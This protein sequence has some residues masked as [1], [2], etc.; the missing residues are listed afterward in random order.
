M[1]VSP[2][3]SPVQAPVLLEPRIM[4]DAN[5]EWDL[6]S[7]TALSS[8]LSGLAQSFAEQYATID[9]VE[10]SAFAAIGLGEA[11]A[12][13]H[14]AATAGVS[15]LDAVLVAVERVQLA[16]STLRTAV[17]EENLD[18]LRADGSDHSVNASGNVSLGQ[19]SQSGP[20]EISMIGDVS[21]IMDDVFRLDPT[22]RYAYPEI[23]DDTAPGG[24]DLTT[25]VVSDELSIAEILLGAKNRVVSDELSDAEILLGAENLVVSEELSVAEVLLG[26]ENLVV[27]GALSVAETLQGSM[28]GDVSAI[29]DDVFLLDPAGRYAYPEIY[30]D[31]AP[32]VADLA[33]RVVSEE[34]SVDE[35]LLGAEKRVVSEELSVAEILLG[36]ENL[37]VSEE[38]S[39]AEPLL[40]AEKRVVSRELSD[41]EILLGAENLVVSGAHSVAE[42]L[43]GSMIGDVSAI[44]DDVFRLDP[45]G[46]YA[47]PEIYDDTAPGGS[48]LTTRVVSDQLSVAE[49]SL[50]AKNRVVSE[51]LSVAEILL[52]SE[53]LVVSEELSVAEISLGAKNRVVSD[54]LSVAEILLGAENL[55]VSEEPSVAEPLLGA[56]KR[57]VSKELSDLEILLGSE[58]LVVSGAL[59]VAETLQGSMIGDVSAI[60]DDVFL[61][62]PAGRYAYP[63]IYDDT[64]PGVADLAKRVVSEEL[65][66]DEILLGAEKRVVSEELSVAEILLGAENLVVSEEPSVAEPL[67]GAEKRVV[68]RELSDLEILLGAENLVVSGAHSVAE[69]LQGSM[70]GDV[71]AIMD[72]VFRLDPA[73]RYAYPEI[74]D[75]TAPGVT[76]LAKRVV[77]EELSVDEISLGAETNPDFHP[78]IIGLGLNSWDANLIG[79]DDMSWIQGPSLATSETA[80]AEPVE[81]AEDGALQAVDATSVQPATVARETAV[82]DQS[83]LPGILAFDHNP[84]AMDPDSLLIQLDDMESAGLVGSVMA[85]ARSEAG[86]AEPYLDSTPQ[87]MPA[88]SAGLDAAS[89]SDFN[90]LALLNDPA[91]LLG[92][93]YE[94]FQEIDTFFDEFLA[95]I[96]LPIIGD[97]L[98]T[99]L[100]F[101][102]DVMNSVILPALEYAETPLADGSLP[103]T[104]ELINGFMNDALNDVFGTDGVEYLH[105]FLDTSGSTS[106]SF[107]Y[108]A[109]NFSG[110]LFS[111]MLDIDFDFGVPGLNIEVEEGSAIL[112]ELIYSVNIGFGLDA[113]GFFLL[114]DTDEAEV[115]IEFLV[116]AGTFSG[117]MSVLNLLGLSAQAV[118]TDDDGI[119]ISDASTDGGTAR[120]TAFLEADLFGESGDEIARDF[121]NI[122]PLD[123]EGNVLTYERI[124]YLD[125]LDFGELVAFD[126]GADID[127][128]IGVVGNI[129]DPFS[130]DALEIGG[131]QILPNVAAEL[132]LD[133]T[134]SLADG[135]SV[136][137]LG[138]HNVRVDA[139]QLYDALIRPL[140]DPIMSIVGPL[141]EVIDVIF[142]D[143]IG[144]LKDLAVDLIALWFPIIKLGDNIAEIANSIAQFVVDIAD[145]GGMVQFGSFDFT[146]YSDGLVSGET[147]ASDIDLTSLDPTGILTDDGSSGFGTFGNPDDGFSVDIPLLQDPFAALSLLL[148]DFSSVELVRA[149]YTWFNIDSADLDF[150]QLLIDSLDLPGFVVDALNDLEI[151]PLI[152]NRITGHGITMFEVGYDMSG[153]Q[154]FLN[155]YD[156][157]RLFDGVFIEAGEGSLVDVDLDISMFANATVATLGGTG[158]VDLAFNITDPND[159]GVVR[160]SELLDAILY[161]VEN[162]AITP[163]QQIAYLLEG[164]MQFGMS[165][166]VTFL[167]VTHTLY[168]VELPPIE[169]EL[170]DPEPSLVAGLNGNRAGI[171]SLQGLADLLGVGG[172]DE[173]GTQVLNLG[174]RIMGANSD[175]VEDGDD[176][177]VMGTAANR[178]AVALTNGEGSLAGEIDSNATAVV[179]PAG[180]GDNVIDMSNFADAAS[181]R[182]TLTYSGGGQDTIILPVGGLNVVFSGNGDDVITAP[183]NA[184][185]TYIIFAE[186][187]ADTVNIP[188]GNV[189]VFSGDDYGM[190]DVFLTAF[191]GGD[192]TPEGVRALL[193][194]MADD[195]ADPSAEGFYDIG[196]DQ[197]VNLDVLLENY[198]E[199]SQLKGDRDDESIT[200]GS[201]NHILLTGK[202]SDTIR[203]D[204]DGLGQVTV[205]SGAGDDNIEIGG[206]TVFVEGGAGSD[207]IKVNGADVE[208]WG[209]GKAAGER[210]SSGLAS[211]IDA[212]AGNDGDDIIIGGS[213]DDRLYGQGGD[214]LIEGNGGADT[215]AGG[216]GNDVVAGGTFDFSLDG[217]AVDIR[218]VDL[219]ASIDGVLDIRVLDLSDG[220]DVIRGGA[221]DDILIGGGGADIVTG[222]SGLDL[223]AGDFAS[224]VLTG[225]MVAQRIA[226][227]HQDS[228]RQGADTIDSGAMNDILIGGGAGDELRSPSGDNIVLGDFGVV[229]GDNIRAAIASIS[230]ISSSQ[231][232]SDTLTT[233]RGNDQLIGGE[234]GDA[235]NS[236]LGVDILFGDN[237]N[238]DF[239]GLILT[240]LALDTDGDDT[241]VLGENLSGIEPAPA[242]QNDLA[243]GG[244]GD[245][246]V[247]AGVGGLTLIGD[248]GEMVLRQ[249][250]WQALAGYVDPGSAPSDA[251]LAQAEA[252]WF[253]F[254]ALV[255]TARTTANVRDGNDLVTVAGGTNSMALGGGDD[256][257]E[258]MAGLNHVLADDGFMRTLL[259]EDETIILYEMT[260]T[261]MAAAS[262]RDY[263]FA[264]DGNNV[265]IGGEQGDEIEVG[266][267]F[268]LILGDRGAFLSSTAETLGYLRSDTSLLGGDDRIS[269]GA[270]NA[271]IVAGQGADTVLVGAGDDIAVG[272][273]AD[274]THSHGW[275][276]LSLTTT[277]HAQ[278]GNDHLTAA[279]THGD[280]VLMGQTGN[281]VIDGGLDDDLLAGDNVDLEF[282]PSEH[283]FAGQSALDRF[284]RLESV[285]PGVDGDDLLQGS[286]GTDYLVGGF[287]DDNL[288]GGD[289]QDFLIGDTAIIGRAYT[290]DGSGLLGELWIDTNFAYETGGYDLLRGEAGFD[291]MI[292]N[293]GP[294]LFFGDTEEDALFSDG[295]AG[296]FTTQW[297]SD[298]FEQATPHWQLVQV[299]FAGPGAIDIVSKAQSAS[300]IGLSLDQPTDDSVRSRPAMGALT[301]SDR[302]SD[303]FAESGVLAS[304]LDILMDYVMGDMLMSAIAQ[305]M[306]I[307]LEGEALRAAIA[308]DLEAFIVQELQIDSV[309]QMM[310]LERVMTIIEDRLQLN[311]SAAA[312]P[313]QA[314]M[315]MLVAAE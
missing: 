2:V 180:E 143:P 277:N 254:D 197:P 124:V 278:G 289:G 199:I 218:D 65:S 268:N 60:M 244:L 104:L 17:F 174:A 164:V 18:I 131:N 110:K 15:D 170:F 53:N 226:S 16:F 133:A 272:D 103:S 308:A 292:G 237:A 310:L 209:W 241:L 42:T 240:G 211:K 191:A 138:I 35:I 79:F 217:T 294:D 260:S 61:L 119:I 102:D 75:D 216:L 192:V 187:G 135:L 108:G 314:D 57:V 118:T 162:G 295:F 189:I 227:I 59:S 315:P 43:Q 136:D 173:V 280:N 250:A 69:T 8:S 176:V 193:G 64:A 221:G 167:G 233:G 51:E 296:Y 100:T 55:V 184:Q 52:G 12:G 274:I 283:G 284:V 252:A 28:I 259:N 236:G 147:N 77:S 223:I 303:T 38:P 68:S 160:L 149:R 25:R 200:V 93:I 71:S 45:A 132:V 86:R 19:P 291:V 96:D 285:V 30:D 153:I 202:G 293:L 263:I 48:D 302:L 306:A 224:I 92:G 111:E 31:T 204:L 27:S 256:R 154:N 89:L 155:S 122:A 63:E 229:E 40:G 220:N 140:V 177:V 73:G 58:N 107:I 276:I 26:A 109:I 201:G 134:F 116:D 238:L 83:E 183:E 222:A 106:E 128:N 275:E 101:F 298:L 49:N 188:G 242:D 85:L 171:L 126:F 142:Q 6:A 139:S 232:G 10:N 67:L 14:V 269:A 287:G 281:D 159:D 11:S 196:S 157:F 165:A 81:S 253:L 247:T 50:G 62:D 210:G 290:A 262:G 130:G 181:E 288:F 299:N 311:Q 41:L 243:F 270:G 145:S 208:V 34:L 234:A 129:L 245:D 37:V 172:G 97:A 70:I 212:L 76:D 213:G 219:G 297:D 194:L 125:A 47:Y 261:D 84:V 137:A 257:A 206:T 215:L 74:Y 198:T 163:H 246:T 144:L 32:G 36:A 44:M 91:S 13:T 80:S 203:G 117:S 265:I 249:E 56:E 235:L 207:T 179:I 7:T 301:L 146:E 255:D 205:L 225:K 141:L 114:N 24:S 113:D 39:V 190:R 54:E 279:G 266:D 120:L 304:Q 185:G 72:D 105:A 148:G 9:E 282:L 267:G 88:L 251:V 175:M 112:L 123:G 33:K 186:G 66:V 94:I 312:A 161:M 151:G 121:S 182:V 228:G 214:D 307:G 98:G 158:S 4:M 248:S 5:L 78:G 95:D 21:A 22:G 264:A 300:S 127:V 152:S 286:Q 90:A 29:M 258:L 305:L 87:E 231:G 169:L 82:S 150:T 271:I 239:V 46:R 178:F 115:S 168:E 20:D 99:G 156:P 313:H 23:Y 166:E 3:N 230:S 309:T 273:D 195:T 1:S